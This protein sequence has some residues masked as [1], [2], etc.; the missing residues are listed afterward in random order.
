[1]RRANQALLQGTPGPTLSFR[2]LPPGKRPLLLSPERGVSEA[3][4]HSFP[5]P[6]FTPSFITAQSFN[7][8]FVLDNAAI[9]SSFTHFTFRLLVALTYRQ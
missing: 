4:E 9:A 1:M 7:H 6:S 5:T 8:R 3:L 2:I